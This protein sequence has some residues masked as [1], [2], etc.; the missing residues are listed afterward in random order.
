M[1]DLKELEQ[2]LWNK[3]TKQ[4]LSDS[5][6]WTFWVWLRELWNSLRSIFSQE[7]RSWDAWIKKNQISAQLEKFERHRTKKRAVKKP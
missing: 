5:L 3:K 1:T 6:T 2:T 7:S 4:A